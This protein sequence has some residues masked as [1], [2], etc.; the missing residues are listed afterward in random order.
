M[1]VKSFELGEIKGTILFEVVETGGE[2]SLYYCL[3]H[4]FHAVYEKL[5]IFATLGS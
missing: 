1:V 2:V 5:L 4:L 3:S